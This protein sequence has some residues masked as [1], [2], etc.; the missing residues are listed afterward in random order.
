MRRG[1]DM[2]IKSFSTIFLALFYI[3]ILQ[4]HILLTDDA[5][6]M[7]KLTV[8]LITWFIQAIIGANIVVAI[9]YMWN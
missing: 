2:F 9:Y 6:I 3:F 7:M 1:K 8:K 4:S 5:P